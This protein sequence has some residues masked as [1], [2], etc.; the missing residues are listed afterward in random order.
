M[1]TATATTA[2]VFSS[3][4]TPRS[5]PGCRSGLFSGGVAVTSLDPR[6]SFHSSY[7]QLPGEHDM[8]TVLSWDVCREASLR[9]SRE[10]G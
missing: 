6:D 3:R 4:L 1:M 5:Y 7:R 9:L 8:R 10:S 2:V